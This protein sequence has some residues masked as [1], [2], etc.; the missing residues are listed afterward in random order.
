MASIESGL[1]CAAHRNR[2]VVIHTVPFAPTDPP[3]VIPPEE[4]LDALSLE[5]LATAIYLAPAALAVYDRI[6]GVRVQGVDERIG[7]LFAVPAAFIAVVQRRFNAAQARSVLES[8][9]KDRPDVALEGE[10]DE[11]RV[12]DDIL[13]SRVGRL[14]VSQ[15]LVEDGHRKDLEAYGLKRADKDGEP[16]LFIV[17]KLVGRH[18]LNGTQ[19][20][21]LNVSDI[22]V[23]APGAVP[24]Q[25]RVAGKQARGIL[26][27]WSVE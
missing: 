22:L 15:M 6:R 2:F 8:L 9:L 16:Y 3:P 18:L 27:P 7:E 11:A 26:V 13:Y 19:W 21:K 4:E 23:R 14:T 5:V 20:A 12:L 24:G 25:L 17:P 1:R 10:S